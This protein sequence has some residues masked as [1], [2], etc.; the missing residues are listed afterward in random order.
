MFQT[1]SLEIMLTDYRMFLQPITQPPNPT[2]L[3]RIVPGGF[4]TFPVR[5][6][7][8]SPNIGVASV[9]CRSEQS[10]K[11]KETVHPNVPLC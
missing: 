4:A 5:L 3:L 7:Q 6:E 1:K 2:P 8:Q 10:T 11:F 9:G